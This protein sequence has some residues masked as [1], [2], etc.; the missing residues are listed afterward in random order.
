MSRRDG[1]WTVIGWSIVQGTPVV[2]Q[3]IARARGIPARV[4]RSCCRRAEE[5]G[6]LTRDGQKHEYQPAVE[7]VRTDDLPEDYA[8][9]I[10]DARREGLGEFSPAEA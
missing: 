4:V 6:L 1:I 9:F 10:R 8:R 2:P 5:A 3:R 7:L